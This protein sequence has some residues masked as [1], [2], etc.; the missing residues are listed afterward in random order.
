VYLHV[1]LIHTYVAIEDLRLFD[2]TFPNIGAIFPLIG[3]L[4][5]HLVG[6]KSTTL[7]SPWK[8]RVEGVVMG[9][10]T[11]R[12]CNFST[13]KNDAIAWKFTPVNLHVWVK[14]ILCG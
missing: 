10:R 9:P 3:K 12:L 4:Y 8:F 14:H 1:L 2:S 5:M 6:F 11:T 13:I 7:T